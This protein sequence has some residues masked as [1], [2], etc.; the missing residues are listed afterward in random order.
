M[1]KISKEDSLKIKYIGTTE[2]YDGHCLRAYTYFKEEM[3]DIEMAE[4]EEKCYKLTLDTGEII[5][6]HEKEQI[7]YNGKNYVGKDLI[8]LIKNSS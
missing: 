1:L 2:H 6:I 8:N 3:S 7:E 5:Y 4:P